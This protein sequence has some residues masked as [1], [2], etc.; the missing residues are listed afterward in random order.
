[1]DSGSSIS[2][3]N[4]REAQRT[5]GSPGGLHMQPGHPKKHRAEMSE[6]APSRR[7]G[8]MSGLRLIDLERR[9][10]FFMFGS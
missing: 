8:A 6:R 7:R 5:Q 4:P 1:M 2:A 10:N 9:A 3:T